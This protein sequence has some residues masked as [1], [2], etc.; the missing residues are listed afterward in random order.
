MTYSKE[1][2]ICLF[3]RC[4]FSPRKFA[5]LSNNR[6]FVW[7]WKSAKGPATNFWISKSPYI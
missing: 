4:T 3:W 6:I 2:L 1:V 5:F 7:R